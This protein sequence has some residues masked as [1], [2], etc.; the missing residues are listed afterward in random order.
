MRTWLTR[1]REALNCHHQSLN[2]RY[3]GR[4]TTEIVLAVVVVP[5]IL[6]VIAAMVL[7]LLYASNA[8]PMWEGAW[9]GGVISNPHF[10]LLAGGLL[11]VL[12]GLAFILYGAKRKSH[13]FNPFNIWKKP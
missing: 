8:N 4:R 13:E 9:W 6:V 1:M 12:I 3:P 11:G 7:L 2:E 5:M 10:E